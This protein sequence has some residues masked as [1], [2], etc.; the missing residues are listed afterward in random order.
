MIRVL[1]FFAVYSFSKM[2]LFAQAQLVVDHNLGSWDID[3]RTFEMLPSGVMVYEGQDGINGR[4]PWMSDGSATGTA[5]LSN[6]DSAGN[7]SPKGF[8]EL[9][10]YVYFVARA[11]SKAGIYRS[12]LATRQTELFQ[13][14]QHTSGVD[15]S[16]GNLFKLGN[17]II[18]TSSLKIGVEYDYDIWNIGT[19]IGDVSHFTYLQGDNTFAFPSNHKVIDGLL[20]FANGR[21]LWVTSGNVT[22]TIKLGEVRSNLT[23]KNVVVHG[24]GQYFIANGLLDSTIYLY[25]PQS[26]SLALVDSLFLG[27][28]Y[29][30]T[31]E[32]VIGND[33]WLASQ[34]SIFRIN[35]QTAKLS[36]LGGT[37][38]LGAIDNKIV[39]CNGK[40][41]VYTQKT[42]NG[43]TLLCE[44]NPA[45]QQLSTVTERNTALSDYEP[46]ICFGHTLMGEWT[47]SQTNSGAFVLV[48]GQ[49]SLYFSS[50]KSSYKFR[51][52]AT[53]LYWLGDGSDG[54]YGSLWKLDLSTV[55]LQEPHPKQLELTIYPTITKDGTIYLNGTDSHTT[56]MSAQLVNQEGKYV[57]VITKPALG[58]P[59]QFGSKPQGLYYLFLVDMDGRKLIQKIIFQ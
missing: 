27:S 42:I 56:L 3:D 44:F 12:N 2:S 45:T 6:L 39:P 15:Y 7:S 24:S 16:I 52:N 59:L 53:T 33:A 26:G 57:H 23:V 37:F 48:N 40:Y 32:T 11:N 9:D 8:V 19:A 14:L 5:M 22:N 30:P 51:H 55:N 46:P 25:I 43:N 17:R 47:T 28:Y 35:F 4:E 13:G 41:Y 34:N 31:N 38:G 1:I 36:K 50:G 10:G 54:I 58:A 21:Q 20:Y 49:D 18:G 29:F